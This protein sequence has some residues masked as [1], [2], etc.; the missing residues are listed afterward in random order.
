[1][2]GEPRTQ[3]EVLQP[4]AAPPRP[5]G[6][7]G[8]RAPVAET[9]NAAGGAA[10]TGEARPTTMRPLPSG[11]GG[12]GRAAGHPR[13]SVLMPVYNAVEHVELSVRSIL[14]QSC[15]DFEFIIIDDGSDDGSTQVLQRLAAEDPRIRLVSRP[16]TGYIPA[17]NEGLAMARGEFIARL[18]AD[19]LSRADRFELQL[20]A[21]EADPQLVAV[22]SQA[23]TIDVRGDAIADAPVPLSHAE[24]EQHHLSGSSMIHHPAVM[25]RREAVEAIG[26]YDEDLQPCEDF[27]LWL[28]LGEVGRVANLPQKLLTKRLHAESAVV[29]GAADHAELVTRIMRAAWA[30]R[31]LEGEYTHVP[32]ELIEPAEFFRQWGWM[33]LRNRNTK[34]A[35]RY[36]MKAIR[37]QP[38]DPDNY[39]LM[40]CVL[41]GY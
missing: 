10:P 35:F 31:G 24:I 20:R 1:M 15:G 29:S 16:N 22:G 8:A 26:G 7:A 34:V 14:D 30:R 18:D 38:L 4:P 25:M 9:G 5:E 40:F 33:A 3:P 13:I 2:S 28:K 12:C 32:V 39:K 41:R 37:R 6:R 19:D 11:G 36:A 27:D 23:G 17:L 21:L